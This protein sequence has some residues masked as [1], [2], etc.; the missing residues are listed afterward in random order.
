VGLYGPVMQVLIREIGD[1]PVTDNAYSW[2]GDSPRKYASISELNKEA[3]NSRVYAG[4]HYQFT[5]DFTREIGK[6]LGD[7]IADIDLTPKQ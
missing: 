1:I 4:I 3:A 6:K 2:R 5:Q 7:Y